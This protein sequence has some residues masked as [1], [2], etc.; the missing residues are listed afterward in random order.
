MVA[1]RPTIDAFISHASEDRTTVAQ[2]L[3]DLLMHM[4]FVVWFDQYELTLGDS[5]RR[6][7]DR[8]LAECRYGVVLLSAAFF[9]KKWPQKELDGLVARETCG[10]DKVIIPVWHDINVDQITDYSP[11]LADKF[12]AHTSAGL[13]VVA[14]KIA[15]VLRPTRPD[16]GV[17]ASRHL[18]FKSADYP[19]ALPPV[20]GGGCTF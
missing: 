11:V 13:R 17:E 4:G 5:L 7:I 9:V 8:A 3:A 10:G 19:F 16:S 14:Q 18:A 6:Q 12:A 2:P 1:M 15:D 20:A